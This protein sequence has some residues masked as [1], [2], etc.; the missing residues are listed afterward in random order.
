MFDKI[1][2]AN[3]GEIACRIARTARRM[4]MKTVAIYSDADADARHVRHADEAIR[5]GPPEARESYLA[6]DRIVAAAKKAGAEA[7]HPGYGFLS[8]NA[9]F[10]EA[11]DAA[12]LIFIGPPLAALRA[13]GSK[14]EAK[15]LMQ[16][17]G[18]RLTPGYFGEDQDPARLK[19]E[20]EAIG[21][22]VLIKAALGGGGKGMRLVEHPADFDAALAACKREAQA[23]FG[24]DSMLIEKYISRARHIEIQIFADSH[25]ECVSLYERDCSIQRRRQKIIEEAPA[26]GLRVTRRQAM[27]EAAI[28]AAKA[29]RYVGAGT[30]EFILAPDGAFYFM[31]MN[32]RL[33]VEHPV[34][35][36]VTGLDLVEWQFRIAAGE[37][38][39]LRQEDIRLNGHAI[40]ARLY[41]EDTARDYLPASGRVTYLDLPEQGRHIRIDAG[42][43]EG[44]EVTPFYDPMIAKLI[45]W[46]ESR[47]A[48]LARMKQALA[49]VHLAGIA[50]NVA[51]LARLVASPAFVAGAYDTGSIAREGAALLAPEGPPSSDALFVAALAALASEQAGASPWE[52]RDNWRLNFEEPRRLVFE[53]DGET[54]EVLA[55]PRGDAF[56][57]SCGG[58]S[59]IARARIGAHGRLDVEI[60]RRRLRA[61]AVAGWTLFLNGDVWT[62]RQIDPLDHSGAAHALSGGL[63]APM[64]GR[65]TALLAAPGALVGKA[66][67]L[68]AMEA[69]KMEHVILAPFEGRVARFHFQVGDQVTEGAQLLDFEPWPNG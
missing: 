65:V 23:S 20:A 29:V 7:I 63:T 16:A 59:A 3:R 27:S 9:Q 52:A 60:D 30:V 35:E 18:A 49:E 44:D 12:G 54:F 41:A 69:M 53:H 24:D 4:A 39:P 31:E 48:A 14:S 57:L 43:D 50:N 2:I 46:D 5:I 28:A 11:C 21:Y 25:G 47:E 32:T 58:A 17:A 40:E 34:T 62:L 45:V 38:L 37:K 26:P 19:R 13:M 64:S 56:A 10:R 1:L 15:K 67:P 42:V 6:I 8:E 61:T 68:L 36:C 33:Q 22:S 66:A 51:F 55:L